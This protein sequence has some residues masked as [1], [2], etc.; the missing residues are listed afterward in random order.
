MAKR[1]KKTVRKQK[2]P[3]IILLLVIVFLAA[4]LMVLNFGTKSFLSIIETPRSET[5]KIPAEVRQNLNPNYLPTYK[6]PILLYHYVEYV[7]DK[8]DTTRQSLDIEPNVFEQ[9]VKTLKDNGYTFITASQ[10]GEAIDGKRKLPNKP[11]LL[12]F[13]DGHWDV[14]TVVLPILKKYHAKA[15]AYIITGFV[16]GSDF[17]SDK[18]IDD[19]IKSGLVEIGAHTVHHVYLKGKILP[20]VQLDVNQSKNWIE[21]NY[22]IKVA[23]FAYPDGAFDEQAIDVVKAAGYTTAVTTVPGIYQSKQNK[24][25]LFRLRPG[26]RTGQDLINYF[27]Q[28]TFKPY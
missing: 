21:S 14:D 18:Q 22:H 7:T 19:L 9:Q 24:Y 3:L 4:L 17:L 20:I 28:T 10:L 23:S 8:N 26:Y 13:D 6:I 2:N 15:T 16:N 11:V 1:R 12:T 5:K 25:F 27:N